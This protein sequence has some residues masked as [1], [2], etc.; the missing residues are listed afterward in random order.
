MAGAG[1]ELHGS[2]FCRAM[3]TSVSG[4]SLRLLGALPAACCESTE[5]GMLASPRAWE[6]FVLHVLAT[7]TA[8]ARC[9]ALVCRL[10]SAGA[11]SGPLWHKP[12]C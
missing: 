4:I 12:C 10:A 9:L 1:T 2:T 5:P 11:G 8:A 7:P 6:T 3:V